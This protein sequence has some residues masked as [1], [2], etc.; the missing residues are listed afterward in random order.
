MSPGDSEVGER[1]AAVAPAAAS[2][3]PACPSVDFLGLDLVSLDTAG[4]VTWMGAAAADA[5]RPVV[6]PYLNAATVNTARSSPEFRRSLRA[7]DP[8]IADGQS[9]VWASRYLGVPVP[10]RL[11]VTD[12]V[13]EVLAEVARQNLTVACVGGRPGEADRFVAT[14]RETIPDLDVVLTASG[15]VDPTEEADLV[16][17]LRDADPDVVLMGMGAPLQEERALRWSRGDEPRLWWCV[18]ACFE[19]FAGTQRRA[20]VWMRRAGLEWLFRLAFDPI[21]LA[22]RYLVGNPRFVY[23]VVTRRRIPPVEGR[24]T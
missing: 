9:I 7:A 20:P 16:D 11:N 1:D 3:L 22:G 17:A 4:F 2:A 6:V 24:S 15:Y 18:G 12:I 10:E 5:D 21:R 14:M 23:G 13:G 19:Y 8:A